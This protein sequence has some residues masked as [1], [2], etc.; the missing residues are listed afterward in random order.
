MDNPK[1]LRFKLKGLV[2][3][4]DI[5]RAGV[6]VTFLLCGRMTWVWIRGGEPWKDHTCMRS[7]I[8][9]V[10]RIRVGC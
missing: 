8:G 1:G 3:V 4:D 7:Q 2:N 5:C 9:A 10:R 6:P